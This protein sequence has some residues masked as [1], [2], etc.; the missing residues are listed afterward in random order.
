[1]YGV[2]SPNLLKCFCCQCYDT[3]LRQV[4]CWGSSNHGLKFYG[5]MERR[6]CACMEEVSKSSSSWKGC[7]KRHDSSV[8]GI[9]FPTVNQLSYGK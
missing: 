1:M 5:R 8:C 2:G 9:N 4:F 6:R 7:G 3:L